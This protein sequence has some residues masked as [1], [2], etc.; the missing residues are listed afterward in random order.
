MR[1]D[2]RIAGILYILLGV[3]A[4]VRLIY[5]PNAVLVSGNAQATAANI[6]SH[7]ALFRA[8]ILADV[9]AGVLTLFVT[10]ALFRLFRTVDRDL[11]SMMLILGGLMVTPI[12][13]FNLV[14]DAGALLVAHAP[15]YLAAFDQKQ[16]E[17]L[18]SVKV[19]RANDSLPRR[20]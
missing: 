15:S 1:R 16:R 12:Y 5:I 3:I 17:G 9:V 14:I 20:L 10:M 13:F 11:A 6:A 18:V 19:E 2:A 4:P 8:A 7:E